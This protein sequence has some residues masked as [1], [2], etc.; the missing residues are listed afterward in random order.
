LLLTATIPFAVLTTNTAQAKAGWFSALNPIPKET[1]K[2]IDNAVDSY[3]S[4][5]ENVNKVIDWFK[6]IKA[7]ISEISIDFMTWTFEFLTK[8]VLHTPAFLFDTEWL[9]TNTLT[10]TGMA[11]VMSSVIVIYEG[12]QR[13]FGDI[14]KRK[15]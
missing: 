7:N 12:F 3:H 13:M 6:N 10:F 14:V 9:K 1:Q 11:V 8:T 5:M 4:F 2:D 15:N